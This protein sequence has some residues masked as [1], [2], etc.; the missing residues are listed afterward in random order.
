MYIYIHPAHLLYY[1]AALTVKSLVAS[2]NAEIFFGRYKET[3]FSHINRPTSACK[4]PC[5][6]GQCG[7]MLLQVYWPKP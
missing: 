7:H 4:E 5:G 1:D 3:L 2:G 6:L